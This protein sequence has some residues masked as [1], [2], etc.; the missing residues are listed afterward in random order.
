MLVFKVISMLMMPCQLLLSSLT[1]QVHTTFKAAHENLPDRNANLFIIKRNTDNNL[2][3]YDAK[4]LPDKT[5]DPQ[6]PVEVYWIRNTEGGIKKELSYMQRT[7]AY[8]L[9]L[10]KVDNAYEGKIAAYDKRPIKITQTPSGMPIAY[11]I[12]NGKWQQLQQV[13]LHIADAKALVPKITYIQLFGK[14]VQ[15]GNSV[16]EKIIL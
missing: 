10:K 2:V 7:M 5:L 11:I 9:S 12:I 8:G 14:D 15:T 16:S 13:Y 1:F 3:V 4:V 6:N